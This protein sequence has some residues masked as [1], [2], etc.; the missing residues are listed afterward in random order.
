MSN[1]P[2]GMKRKTIE[3]KIHKKMEEWIETI[4]DEDLKELVLTN[5]I[6]TGGCIASMLLGEKIN[7]YD[8]YFRDIDV[9]A[10]VAKYYVNKFD[11]DNEKEFV[12]SKSEA[13][14]Q[15]IIQ[16]P[17]RSYVVTSKK[18]PKDGEK[19]VPIGITS[20]A[21]TLSNDV[22][23]IIRF[24]GE[25]EEIHKNYDFVH[26]TAYMTHDGL[27]ISSSVFESLITRELKYVGSLYPICSMFRIRKFLA[28]GFTINAGEMF[29]IAWDINELDLDSPAVLADQLVGVDYTYFRELL[30]KLEQNREVVNRDYVFR[31]INDIF[32]GDVEA[33]NEADEI[34][35]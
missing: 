22:Q 17:S 24:V 7:D 30:R 2:R 19:Y 33:M 28:R 25:P 5:Y 20:N 32:D 16:D 12:I 18:E 8:V 31:L 34:L 14:D 29:K 27:D 21:I 9:A 11:P 15:I 1:M 35:E 23:L 26:C 4:G 6:V 3:K 13:N 10:K